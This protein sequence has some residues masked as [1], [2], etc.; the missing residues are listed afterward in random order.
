MALTFDKVNKIITLLSPDTEIAI[1]DL[2]NSIREW[3]DELTSMDVPIVAFCAGKESLGGGVVVGLTLTLL[4]DWQLAFEARTGPDYIQCKVSGGNIVA[5][6]VNG[7]IYPTAFTQVLIT[8]S[9]SATQ[10]DL[11]AIQ[12][13]SYGGGVTIDVVNGE[14]G[15][16]YPIGTLEYPVNNLTD[17]LIIDS[18]RF[19]KF[20]LKS[21]M[22]VSEAVDISGYLV[23]GIGHIN[24]LTTIEPAVNVEGVIA[25]NFTVTGVLDGNITIVGCILHDCEFI[26]GF[27]R[28]C[29]FTGLFNL[30]GDSDTSISDCSSLNITDPPTVDFGSF[31]YNFIAPNYTGYMK[32]TNVVNNNKINI[33]LDA[34]RVILTSSVT[35]GTVFVSGVGRLLDESGVDIPVGLWNGGVT[36]AEIPISNQSIVDSVFDESITGHS[37]DGSAGNLFNRVLSATEVK[38]SAVNDISATT[39]KFI[40]TLSETTDDFWVRASVIF[41]SGQNK[42]QVRAV[43]NYSGTTKEITFQ[44]P[45]SFPPNNTDTFIINTSRQFSTPNVSDIVNAIQSS[46][47]EGSLTDIEM[48]RIMFAALSGLCSGGGTNN[49][50]F[51]DLL[52]VKDRIDV[53]VVPLTGDR[54]TITLDGT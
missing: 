48:K 8:A 46:V 18:N 20:Y 41:T 17:A 54:T 34:G 2:L 23:E 44:T 25:Y 29:F 39:T 51:R 16:D 31:N 5:V 50:K 6:N 42:G 3:E 32:I 4:N 35:T 13:A 53:T 26:N 22:V 15:T 7:P 45:L 12:Y 52:D 47:V 21:D 43:K 30:G 11:K 28:N 36:I 49:I 27:A 40:S 19:N 1:Q 24:L 10:S 37:F 9:S 33:G 14:S 38:E